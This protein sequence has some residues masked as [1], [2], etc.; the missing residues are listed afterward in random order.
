MRQA[1]RG[2]TL[3]MVAERSLELIPGY[4]GRLPDQRSEVIPHLK[5]SM[6]GGPGRLFSLQASFSPSVLTA[7][8]SSGSCLCAPFADHAMALFDMVFSELGAEQFDG[9]EHALRR[10]PGDRTTA[11]D[12]SRYRA[13]VRYR[14]SRP[15]PCSRRSRIPLQ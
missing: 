5:S 15:L 2:G 4:L 6:V 12:A 9:A 13:T 7:L 3:G 1:P 10:R 11:G 8:D 14:L